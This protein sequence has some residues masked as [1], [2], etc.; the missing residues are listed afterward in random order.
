MTNGDRVPLVWLT[1]LVVLYHH[2]SSLIWHEEEGFP[3]NV[4]QQKLPKVPTWSSLW[5]LKQKLSPQVS[6]ECI[7]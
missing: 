2:W 1:I 5:P 3:S 6:L 4:G 7:V